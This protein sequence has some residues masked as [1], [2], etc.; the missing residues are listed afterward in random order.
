MPKS[1]TDL[2]WNARALTETDNARVN[3]HDTVQR[4]LELDFVF[5]QLPAAG[6]VLEVG[7]G[8]GFVTRQL[9][10]RCNRVDAFD[11]AENMVERGRST[12]GET[13]NRFFHGSVLSR[14]TC[15]DAAYDAVVCIRVLINLRDLGEQITAI[16]NIAHWLKPGGKLILVEG[17]RDGFD[18]LNRLRQSCGM[19]ALVPAPINFYSYLSE[20]QPAL[21]RWFESAGEFHT[22]LFDFLTR[23]VYPQLVAPNEI[24]ASDDFHRKI[25]PLVHRYNPGEMRDL[26]RVLGFALVKQR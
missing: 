4:D 12:Y 2:H 9:R 7:C 14:T 6:K 25:E 20:L 11:Y 23:V 16:E 18:G 17:Y 13:N 10:E 21:G 19:P 24:G 3:I 5:A 15:E 1:E 8:N 22:G 26:A